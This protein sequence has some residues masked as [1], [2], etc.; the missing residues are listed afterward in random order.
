M[1]VFQRQKKRNSARVQNKKP[2]NRD[3][4]KPINLIAGKWVLLL[5]GKLPEPE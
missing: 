4:H 2:L 5:R 1:P 3:G